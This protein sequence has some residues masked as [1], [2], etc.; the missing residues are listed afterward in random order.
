MLGDAEG[1][2]VRASVKF[3]PFNL[4]GKT[5]RFSSRVAQPSI[6]VILGEVKACLS[7]AVFCLASCLNGLK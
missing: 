4:K 5:K 6:A 2:S 3:L 7:E 1:N